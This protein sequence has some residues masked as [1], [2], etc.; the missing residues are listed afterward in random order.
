[1]T[2]IMPLSAAHKRPI[3][4]GNLFI[5]IAIAVA[6]PISNAVT[7]LLSQ[8]QYRLL[9][10][11]F[12]ILIRIGIA[13]I[14]A[15]SL[16]LINGITGQFSL[17]HCGFMAIGAY[18]CGVLAR[19]G[20]PSGWLQGPT[21][22]GA[23]LLAGLLA[24]AAGVVVGVP[25]LRLRGDYL[26]IA[27]LGFGQIIVVV[28]N[29]TE[30]IGRFTVGGSAGLHDI[31][32]LTNF[33]WTFAWALICIVTVWRV[34]HCLKGKSFWAVSEDEI[35]SAAV[36]ID[37]TRVKVIAF[38]LGAFFA[39][40]AG[41]LYAMWEGNLSPASFNFMKSIEV[42]VMV[43][44]G[45]SGSIAGSILAAAVLTW[46]PEQLRFMD[47]WRLVIYALLLIGMMLIRPQGL[48]GRKK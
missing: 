27:T 14:L 44:L 42:V 3:W 2:E 30:T 4:L 26:A 34:S 7:H 12:D 41:G 5:L 9:N 22:L 39:G 45:G 31:P 29:K 21:M 1:M 17:G 24:A 16:N 33:F 18:A 8:S 36:G 10:Y 6:W 47:D 38:V 48:L 43:V 11:H 32:I 13:V 23:M 46:L 19:Q 25:S 20:F 15:V 35:A 28:L 40:V 37:P